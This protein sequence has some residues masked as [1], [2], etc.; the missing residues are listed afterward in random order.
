M[1]ILYG[2]LPLPPPCG[3][4][5]NRICFIQQFGRLRHASLPNSLPPSICTADR[6]PVQV[7]AKSGRGGGLFPL[8]LLLLL[9]PLPQIRPWIRLAQLFTVMP[10]AAA[11]VVART[12]NLHVAALPLLIPFQKASPTSSI[13]SYSRLDSH[14]CLDN[15]P[16]RD[17][18]H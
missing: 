15:I 1:S 16:H 17:Q 8:G 4:N 10:L 13:C 3:M 12:A 5:Q 2:G 7:G 9:P 18:V 11:A 14:Y 6:P